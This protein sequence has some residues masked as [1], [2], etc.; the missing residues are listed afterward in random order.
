MMKKLLAIVSAG[1][2]SAS[3]YA[4][5]FYINAGTNWPFDVVDT[6]SKTEAIRTLGLTGSLATSVYY[7]AT[8]T[9]GGTLK[10]AD[11]FDSNTVAQLTP[12]GYVPGPNQTTLAGT[13]VNFHNPAGPGEINID[14]LNLVNGSGSDTEGFNA[15]PSPPQNPAVFK[16][17]GM[18]FKYA[19][20]GKLDID[21]ALTDGQAIEYTANYIDLFYTGSSGLPVPTQVL[22]LQVLD[23]SL[24]AANLEISGLVTFDFNG[25]APSDDAAGNPFVENFFHDIGTD[26]SFYD[27]WLAGIPIEF[28]FDTNVV[29][30]I[31]TNNQLVVSTDLI[32]GKPTYIRQA[33]LNS[34]IKFNVAD[35]VSVPSPVPLTL[36]GVSLLGFA[37]SRKVIKI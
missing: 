37:A 34:D 7:N 28:A 25:G 24:A 11:I 30:P 22:R 10:T 13:T 14:N 2:F 16:F 33:T 8:F 15:S 6:D 26:K 4:G 27:L 20:D 31:P 19:L 1:L 3:A 21:R 23:S 32:T 17:W 36:I 35:P 5:D 12:Y 9:P 29:P 18:E